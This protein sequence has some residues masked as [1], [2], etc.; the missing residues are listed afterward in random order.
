MPTIAII[1][2]KGGAGKTTLALHLAAA[3][4]DEGRV[5]LV[6]DTD[7]QAT[8]SQ[9][10]AWRQDAPPEV[11]DSPPPRLSA[12]IEQARGQGAD[13]IV[14]DTPPHADSAARAAVEV[15]DLVLIPCRPSAF[16]LAAIQTTAK[17]VQLL[18]KPAFVVFTAGSPNAPRMYQEAGELVEG[19]G[20]PACP[21]QIADRAAFRHAS[22]E[23]RTVMEF[24]PN[25]KAADDIRHIYKWTCLQLGIPVKS[26]KKPSSKPLK[27]NGKA[28]V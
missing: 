16:D 13:F 11:I 12:K 24:E 10:A 17:L 19:F 2:Q 5:A 7:P 18:R 21:I 26:P 8:A 22:A 9:W 20:T 14:I 4:H 3:A 27:D 6:I 28:V 15:A 25:G 1:S 23:G